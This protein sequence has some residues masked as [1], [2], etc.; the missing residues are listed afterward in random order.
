[1]LQPFVLLGSSAAEIGMPAAF[2]LIGILCGIFILG[3]QERSDS[4]K[5]LGMSLTLLGGLCTYFWAATAIA[6][7]PVGWG[8]LG[9]IWADAAGAVG[10]DFVRKGGLAALGAALVPCAMA[11]WGPPRSY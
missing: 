8:D 7:G 5:V 6:D 4:A 3:P 11:L 10:T 2:S 9:R 1:M